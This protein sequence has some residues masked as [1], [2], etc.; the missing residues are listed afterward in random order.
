MRRPV[1][2]A[3]AL[4]G[5][6]V[7]GTH[8]LQASGA[9][10]TA[11]ARSN[12]SNQFSAAAAFTGVRLATGSY[13]GDAV[14][15]R[16]IT[17]IGFTPEIVIVKGN[18]AQV[19][20][21]RSSTMTG[22]ASKPLGGATALTANLIQSLDAN[23]FTLG[24]DARV[25]A[26]GIAFQWVAIRTRSD[27]VVT[28]NYTGNGAN[29]SITG[30]P[31]SPEYVAVLSAGANAPVERF[32]GMTSSFRFDSDAGTTTRI[33]A[34]NANGFSVGTAAEVNTNG[35]VY[36]YLAFNDT[37]GSIKVGSYTGTAADNRNI[38]GVGF[39]PQYLNLRANDTA[40]ARRGVH[41]PASLS[42]D[43][44][45]GFDPQANVANVIQ[46]IQAD[47]F[48]VGTDAAANANGV[49]YNYLALKNVP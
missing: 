29:R 25:N 42:G 4:L 15:N 21:L 36:H 35:T 1:V 24:N 17:G 46:A 16:A 26:S 6:A 43:A 37:V 3:I 32:N 23:G 45:L 39:Q 40:T 13:T 8:G 49:T 14:D 9:N 12:P 5:A 44:A 18:N 11:T 30:L 28:G 10:F 7:I 19:A 22:D 34:L 2:V 48:Q 27:S 47:G 31:F 38:T 41:R 33:T 20:V